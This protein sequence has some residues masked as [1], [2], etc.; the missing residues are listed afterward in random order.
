MNKQILRAYMAAN[1]PDEIVNKPDFAS[2]PARWYE[3]IDAMQPFHTIWAEWQTISPP[4]K[5]SR[6]P[7][8][9]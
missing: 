6:P 2:T 4:T 1:L 5:R 3:L 7:W 9:R 8:T